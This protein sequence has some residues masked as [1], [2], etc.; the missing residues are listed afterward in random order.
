MSPTIENVQ[1]FYNNNTANPA[2]ITAISPMMHGHHFYGTHPMSNGQNRRG[3]GNGGHH[4]R[5]GQGRQEII[6]HPALFGPGGPGPRRPVPNLLPRHPPHFNPPLLG[7]RPSMGPPPPPGH[8]G[9]DPFV[10]EQIEMLAE[11]IEGLEGEL[12][13]AWRALDV[14]SQEYVK[15]WQRLEKMEG[16]LSEQQTVITQLIDLYSA[17]S[18]D[19]G[20]TNGLKSGAAS[21][22]SIKVRLILLFSSQKWKILYDL[23]NKI[24][25]S[26]F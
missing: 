20:G 1:D 16:L 24:L 4:G 25:L 11:K 21:P 2:V 8:A 9:P 26:F 14:L 5:A 3:G 19:G 22:T 17:D 23:F 15:M 12:R 18:S 13:Y 10:E 7:P 6:L